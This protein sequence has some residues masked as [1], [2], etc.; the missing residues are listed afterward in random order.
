MRFQSLL[1]W[2]G[3]AGYNIHIV[4]LCTKRCF[5]PCCG[6]SGSLGRRR[7]A[8]VHDDAAVSILVVVDRARWGPT[9]EICGGS[10][11]MFQSLL[12]WIGL[13]G[14]ALR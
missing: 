11:L 8:G 9:I 14:M 12:W 6:G 1:W 10:L 7:G 13:A 5:N 2:I 4:P 3:L